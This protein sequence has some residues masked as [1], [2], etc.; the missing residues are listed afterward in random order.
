MTEQT[1]DIQQH[2]G[3]PGNAKIVY[4]LYFISLVVGITGL[5]GLVMA[6]IYKSDAP[7][8]LRDHYR[9][10]I[11][12]FWIGLLYGFIGVVTAMFL[13]GY[14][15]LLFTLVWFIVR[16]VKGL[17]RLEKRQPLADSGSWMF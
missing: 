1:T 8:W 5:V 11:R 7:D 9:W 15:I 17:Q 10:Q 13:V 2:T 4:I 16:C 6:Y 14:L 3:E 12:T